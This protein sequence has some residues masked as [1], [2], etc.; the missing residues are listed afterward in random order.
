MLPHVAPL[1]AA[2]HGRRC[3]AAPPELLGALAWPSSH[4]TVLD[5]A[6]PHR[7]SHVSAAQQA[8]VVVSTWGELHL[9]CARNDDADPL[10]GLGI[11]CFPG[12]VC[13]TRRVKVG[14]IW[15][16]VSCKWLIRDTWS[17]FVP[18]CFIK[19]ILAK[20]APQDMLHHSVNKH[21]G[22]C[23]AD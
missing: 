19:E 18:T 3:A 11:F 13:G 20:L 6:G 10:A 23:A 9:R 15:R 1:L 5:G 12:G 2:S 14:R 17:L 4:S 22:F 8:V 21:Q 7:L 16:F